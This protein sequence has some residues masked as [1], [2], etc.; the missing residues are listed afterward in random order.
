MAAYT[1]KEVSKK[2][3]IPPR[4][5]RQWEKEFDGLLVIPR[6]KQGARIFT[7]FEINLLMKLKEMVEKNVS[8]VLIRKWIQKKLA[9]K[10]DSVTD[11]GV[12]TLDT[13]S[14]TVT[15]V[16]VNES[17]LKHPDHFFEAM[18]TYKENFLNEVKSEIRSVIR[19]E[20]VEEV[21]KEILN[22]TYYTVKA[23]SDSIYKSTANTKAEIQEIAVT[24]DKNA[25]NTAVSLQYLSNSIANV[26]ME[27]TEE[28]FTL[29]KQLSE[30]SD[31]LSYYVD[32]TNNEIYSLTEA[33][34]KDREYLI[35]ERNQYR[36]EIRQREAAFQNM[37]SG[38]R[39]V[40]GTK[41]KKWWKFW[42]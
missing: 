40:A 41:E 17:A 27:A 1:M 9:L 8:K 10:I 7:D 23:L 6:S 26:S 22:G 14:E 29:S 5:I 16:P 31:E 15:P 30:T 13:V 21:K 3:N 28:I 42:S 24:L 2:V 32:V 4:T 39:D 19:K 20:V 37:L 12:K 36:H 11:N 18:D 38:F 35:E 34:S 25:E 33:I